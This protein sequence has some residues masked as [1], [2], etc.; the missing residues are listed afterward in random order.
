MVDL[1]RR[2]AFADFLDD[3]A[4][5][6]FDTGQWQTYAVAHYFDE[7]LE[8]TRR[9]CVRLSIQVQNRSSWS[10]AEKAQLSAW[11]RELRSPPPA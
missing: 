6:N 4:L 3:L 9:Q 2:R 1:D 7:L 8:E 10:E 11:A 5:G